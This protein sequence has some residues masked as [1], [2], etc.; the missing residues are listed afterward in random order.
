VTAV[1]TK[2]RAALNP[3]S[4]TLPTGRARVKLLM[5]EPVMKVKVGQLTEEADDVEA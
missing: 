3:E 2:E 1:D 5:I 4:R